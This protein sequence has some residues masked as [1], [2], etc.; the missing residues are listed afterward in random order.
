MTSN[1]IQDFLKPNK[2]AKTHQGTF[3]PM[4]PDKYIGNVSKIYYRSGWEFEFL[5]FCDRDNR[6]IRYSSE[7]VHVPYMNP[8][9]RKAHR[10]FIDIYLEMIDSGGK[11]VKWWIEIKPDK[12]TKFP[13]EPKRKSAK[14]MANYKRHYETTLVNIEKFKSAKYWSKQMGCNFGV[15]SMDKK[16]RLFSLV[17]WDESLIKKT[18][19]S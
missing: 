5:K 7:S 9:D 2:N 13:T 10:Y 16:T 18:N 6:I 19:E 15:A 3:I 11:L 4:N 17:E 1:N 12:Y 14:A 8:I